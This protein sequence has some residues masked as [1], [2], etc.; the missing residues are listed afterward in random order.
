MFENFAYVLNK[1]SLNTYVDIENNR[2]LFNG[3]CSYNGSLYLMHA[4]L[5]RTRYV[6]LST[7]WSVPDTPFFTESN[8]VM[9]KNYYNY[10]N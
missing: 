1:W 4:F 9:I 6:L 8:S 3:S 2:H 5:L 7:F 10:N